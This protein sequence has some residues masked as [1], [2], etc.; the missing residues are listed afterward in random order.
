MSC[1]E[2][3]ETIISGRPCSPVFELYGSKSVANP[4][5]QISERLGGLCEAEV[6]PPTWQ[7]FPHLFSHLGHASSADPFGDGFNALLERFDSL[8]GHSHLN[9]VSCP[10]P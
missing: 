1:T 5:I 4:R 10:P 3:P 9:R 2:A 8:G 7:V 6:G